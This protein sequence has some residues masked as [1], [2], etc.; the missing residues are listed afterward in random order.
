[1]GAESLSLVGQSPMARGVVDKVAW[2]PKCHRMQVVPCAVG[3]LE[4]LRID[5][6]KP[7]SEVVP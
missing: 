2:W 1:M 7:W 5:I 4:L 6:Q 3:N